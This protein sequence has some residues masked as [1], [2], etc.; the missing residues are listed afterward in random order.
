[1]P[2]RGGLA[3]Y[4]VRPLW[5]RLENGGGTPQLITSNGRETQAAEEARIVA[6]TLDSDH[7][8]AAQV[9]AAF[10]DLDGELL[11]RSLDR[12]QAMKVIEPL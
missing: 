12:L 4:R 3:R 1:M 10:S 9:S 5:A 2:S 11:A 8:S 7:F 6:W